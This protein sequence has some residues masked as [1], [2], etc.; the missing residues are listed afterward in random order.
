MDDQKTSSSPRI[1]V[2][3]GGAVGLTV[4]L[5]L[6]LQGHSVA[7][8][9]AAFENEAVPAEQRTKRGPDNRTAALFPGSVRLLERLGAWAHC[10]SHAAPLR[11][12]HIIDDRAAWLRAPD[13]LFQ[14]AELGLD[15]L[16]HN[17]A[18]AA[19]VAALRRVIDQGVTTGSMGASAMAQLQLAGASPYHHQP[20]G[21]DIATVEGRR[22]V[23]LL[24]AADGRGSPARQ[25]AGLT[26]R[27]WSYPQVAITTAFDHSRPHH[28]VSTE[29]HRENGPLT[30]VPLPGQRSS[31]VWVEGPAQADALMQLDDDAF[32]AR[33]ETRLAGLLG[34]IGAI[35]G[36][37][38]FP[39]TGL[40]AEQ[41]AGNRTVLLGE[42]AHVFPPI[43]AQGLNLG[44]RD[45][46]VLADC[47][48]PAGDR[49]D[50]PGAE[51]KLTAYHRARDLD[52]RARTFAVDTLD[53]SLLS[54]FVP[55]HLLRGLGLSMAASLPPV[56]R[57]LMR[58]GMVDAL[59]DPPL[60][61]P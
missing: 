4:A 15:A 30:V 28:G 59:G 49:P 47:L 61:R 7:L 51:V 12:I 46:A 44:L 9:A 34:S 57:T 25:A 43:G 33:L 16:A 48:A 39:L 53:R 36:R 8:L 35:D 11:A 5:A 45:A 60:M 50:D 10:A 32:R 26:A 1:A 19:L 38:H 56:R 37:S 20:D 55:T 14:A 18:N 3:G 23:S 41:L 22:R 17:I 2:T 27:S 13:V 52:V 31:L 42:A 58:Q 24:V 40:R 29:L 21:I 54:S 6:A